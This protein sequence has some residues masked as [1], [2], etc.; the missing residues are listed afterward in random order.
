[1]PMQQT[2]GR[3]QRSPAQQPHKQQPT[4]PAPQQKTAPSPNQSPKQPVSRRNRL[5]RQLRASMRQ[6][7]KLW[8]VCIALA[9]ALIAVI[10]GIVLIAR[11]A[12]AARQKPEEHWP[13]QSELMPDFPSDE[14]SSDEPSS[15]QPS[16][17]PVVPKNITVCIDPGH[18]FVKSTGN[19]DSGSSASAYY[20]ATG[21][22]EDGFTLRMALAL[23]KELCDR[24][25]TVVMTRTEA[26]DRVVDVEERD[27]LINAFGADLCISIHGNEAGNRSVTGSW[28]MV[29]KGR[30]NSLPLAEQVTEAVNRAELSEPAAVLRED[31][32]GIVVLCALDCPS[33]LIEAAFLDN[34]ADAEKAASP[35]W[36]N[37]YAAAVADGID[38]FTSGK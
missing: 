11:S 37:A 19:Y 9:L 17:P 1:M 20:A 36:Q 14:L 32:T 34:S 13:T 12:A 26:S 21:E 2:P 3:P 28:I 27:D 4:R 29:Q 6:E 7:R 30:E 25:Y 16:E 18:G 15:E 23:Q 10:V 22:H 35:A 5:V 33:I 24:G 8:I 31:N 38:A